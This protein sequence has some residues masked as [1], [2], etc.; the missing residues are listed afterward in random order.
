[1]RD[2]RGIKSYA[3]LNKLLK[4]APIHD[5]TVVEYARL[6]WIT[7]GNKHQNILITVDMYNGHINSVERVDNGKKYDL[8]AETSCWPTA[9]GKKQFINNYVPQY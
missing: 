9:H 8:Y 6:Y 5:V 3:S 2:L 7:I 1:M 4:D